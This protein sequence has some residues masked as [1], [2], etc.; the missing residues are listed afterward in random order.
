MKYLILGAGRMAAGVLFDLL[1][2][3]NAEEIFVTDIS[4][5]ALEETSKRFNDRRISVHQIAADQKD[6]I[7]DLMAKADGA[8]SAVPYD[9][10]VDLT[11]WAIENHCHLV[12]LGGNNRVVEK[13]F[14][15]D[16]NAGKNGVGVV[17][18]CGLAPGMVSVVAVDLLAR[19]PE[20]DT[21][22]IRVGGLP[23]DPQP[24]LNYMLVFS[25]HGLTNEYIEPSVILRDGRITVVP[26]MTGIE[27]LSFP[28]P[29]SQLEAFYTS[30][31]TS[32]LPQT[33]KEKLKNLDYKTIR[34]KGHCGIFKAMIDLDFT[35]EKMFA[36]G[37]TRRQAFEQLLLEPLSYTSDDVVLIRLTAR[38][39]HK[40]LIFEAIEYGDEKNDLTAMMRTTAFPA[41]IILEMLV[42][43]RIKDRGVLRQEQAVPAEEFME[44]LQGRNIRFNRY[45]KQHAL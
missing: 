33:F 9:Y 28:E 10:N 34:Y 23:V 15:L 42:D 3:G 29:F 16:N 37:M 22:E 41:A 39:P 4:K 13:Q 2:F 17:P 30:G 27:D 21:L 25:V 5:Q 8:L 31:G 44:A 35:S 20:A 11:K 14:G 45:E 32:T 6:A 1:K 12:D 24:P 7:C 26:S 40:D 36:R 43:G 19:L 18:D 38:S